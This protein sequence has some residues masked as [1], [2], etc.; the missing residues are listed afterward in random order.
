MEDQTMARGGATKRQQEQ[1]LKN[2]IGMAA[3]NPFE[4]SRSSIDTNIIGMA[5][6]APVLMRHTNKEVLQQV[7]ASR[8]ELFE[9]VPGHDRRS[10]IMRGGTGQTEAEDFQSQLHEATH[11]WLIRNGYTSDGSRSPMM[12]PETGSE[13]TYRK[14]SRHPIGRHLPPRLR[15]QYAGSEVTL[16][17]EV[18]VRLLDVM[19][20][21]NATK[22]RAAEYISGNFDLDADLLLNNQDVLGYITKVEKFAE[23]RNKQG[24]GSTLTHF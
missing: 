24:V 6:A 16:P 1:L 9:E 10:T 17:H 20:G 5:N 21:P 22:H 7:M 18:F 2:P 15:K 19:H 13:F 11:T 4:I 8:P 3:W 12:N 14:E 23:S